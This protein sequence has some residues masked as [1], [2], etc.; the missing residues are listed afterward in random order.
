MCKCSSPTVYCFILIVLKW[1]LSF[2]QTFSKFWFWKRVVTVFC[3]TN[4]IWEELFS[5]LNGDIFSFWVCWQCVIIAKV[6]ATDS[7]TPSHLC[8]SCCLLW[9]YF[10]MLISHV[11]SFVIILEHGNWSV[12]HLLYFLNFVTENIT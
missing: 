8:G 3:R 12:T 4:S 11:N 10:S 7:F 9:Y 1:K 6:F 2:I 5:K